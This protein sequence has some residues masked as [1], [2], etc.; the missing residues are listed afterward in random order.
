M[1][2]RA[3]CWKPENTIEL[4]IKAGLIKE[5]AIVKIMLM[6]IVI[7]ILISKY[8]PFHIVQLNDNNSNNK[9]DDI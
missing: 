8:D 5:T 2:F 9:F 3:T 6:T 7:V 1:I 4:K